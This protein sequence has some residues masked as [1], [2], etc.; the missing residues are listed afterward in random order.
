MTGNVFDL[1]TMLFGPSQGARKST[2]LAASTKLS[3]FPDNERRVLG[4]VALAIAKW[5]RQ[6][7]EDEIFGCLPLGPQAVSGR[8]LFR[9]SFLED[10]AGEPYGLASGIYLGRDVLKAINFHSELLAHL[11]PVP[12]ENGGIGETPALVRAADFASDSQAASIGLEWRDISLRVPGNT[13]VLDVA[14]HVLSGVR[15]KRLQRRIRG[16]VTSAVF[17]RLGVIDPSQSFQL[18]TSTASHAEDS[19]VKGEW[20]DG[21]YIGP[22]VSPPPSWAAWQRIDAALAD[23]AELRQACGW[24]E[25]FAN[26]EAI[27]LPGLL[28]DRLLQ[29][30]ESGAGQFLKL[31]KRLRKAGLEQ[32]PKAELARRIF[33]TDETTRMRLLPALLAL[34]NSDQAALGVTDL[35]SENPVLAAHLPVAAFSALLERGD[36]LLGGAV[37]QKHIDSLPEDSLVAALLFATK[38]IG[39]GADEYRDIL[40]TTLKV[41]IDKSR[42]ALHRRVDRHFVD[43]LESNY[44]SSFLE[45]NY[46]YPYYLF[47][48]ENE[49]PAAKAALGEHL[50][51]APQMPRD[52]G[53]LRELSGKFATYLTAME[54]SA[55]QRGSA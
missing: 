44:A 7:E 21:K 11:L 16:W 34:P 23:D 6:R 49:E 50:A 53:G 40:V 38:K 35:F 22:A 47:L 8:L 5:L 41:F 20:R 17:P 14:R 19:Y 24:A 13:E 1:P 12:R 33:E 46:Q 30:D 55:A 15:D 39:S 43:V 2:I 45:A 31:L 51:V 42:I 54:N 25:M 28:Y 36:W 4:D 29:W 48:R 26:V 52:N 32:N 9:A 37:R 3:G 18:V 10:L 27:M